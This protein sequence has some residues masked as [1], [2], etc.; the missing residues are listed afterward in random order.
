LLES[1]NLIKLLEKDILQNSVLGDLLNSFE[2][3]KFFIF[4]LL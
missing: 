1:T 2:Q 3:F 4:E